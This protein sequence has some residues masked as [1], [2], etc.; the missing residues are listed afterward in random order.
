MKKLTRHRKVL[1]KVLK[2][3]IL[4]ASNVCKSPRRPPKDVG[5]APRL[6]GE[7]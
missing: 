2:A 7:E 6:P 1:H 5:E 4:K 3:V